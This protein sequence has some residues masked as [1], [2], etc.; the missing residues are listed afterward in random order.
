MISYS[1][2]H[3]PIHSAGNVAAGW[4]MAALLFCTLAF[5]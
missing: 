3:S 2:D 5:A 1:F 4:A